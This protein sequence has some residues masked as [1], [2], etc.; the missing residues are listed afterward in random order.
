LVAKKRKIRAST[1]QIERESDELYCGGWGRPPPS[2]SGSSRRS[3]TDSSHTTS[4]HR[5]QLELHRGHAP[6]GITPVST[7]GKTKKTT[8]SRPT[9][10]PSY[11]G[12]LPWP[13]LAGYSSG[14][15]PGA[16]RPPT[17]N[18]QTL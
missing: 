4:S 12:A 14:G 11:S 1:I 17:A 2:A 13:A 5:E 16:V 10:I 7:G 9:P 3:A 18:S 8:R 6:K 15:G